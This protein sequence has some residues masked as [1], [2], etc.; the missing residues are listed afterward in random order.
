MSSHGGPRNPQYVPGAGNDIGG[1]PFPEVQD[2][3]DPFARNPGSS[4]YTP[5]A[6][7]DLGDGPAP[8]PA[9]DPPAYD[10]GAGN[11]W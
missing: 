11:N 4:S 6:G 7:N 2:I 9:E 8:R 5:G 10:P 1:D 3:E